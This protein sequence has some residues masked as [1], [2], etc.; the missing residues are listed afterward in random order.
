MVPSPALFYDYEIALYSHI[1][2][3]LPTALIDAG[4]K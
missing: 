4:M 1:A 3:P 2:F